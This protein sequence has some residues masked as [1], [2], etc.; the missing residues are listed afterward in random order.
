[1]SFLLLKNKTI[2]CSDTVIMLYVTEFTAYNIMQIIEHGLLN[3][4]EINL[5]IK[6]LKVCMV[7]C[8]EVGIGDKG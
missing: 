6:G 3:I 1:M 5:D 7:V 2:H 4:C 8:T